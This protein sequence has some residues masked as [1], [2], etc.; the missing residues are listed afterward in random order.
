MAEAMNNLHKSA[1]ILRR[2]EN[3]CAKPVKCHAL[4]SDFRV[5]EHILITAIIA[6]WQVVEMQTAANR[7]W[8]Y[9]RL[10]IDEISDDKDTAMRLSA[11]LIRAIS[12]VM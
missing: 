3:G 7:S 10:V 4:H 8:R 5:D 12:K 2:L 9:L 6:G 11:V 1:G